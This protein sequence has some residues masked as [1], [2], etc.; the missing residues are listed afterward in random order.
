MDTD[1]CV[2]TSVSSGVCLCIMFQL[3]LLLLHNC[4]IFLDALA[5]LNSKLSVSQSAIDVFRL[6]HLQVFQSY[7]SP[8]HLIAS[9]SSILRSWADTFNSLILAWLLPQKRLMAVK[10]SFLGSLGKNVSQ[11]WAV[12]CQFQARRSSGPSPLLPLKL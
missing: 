2:A 11:H 6:A 3:T 4:L 10:K 5:Y 8:T 12:S 9:T 1:V 7:Y